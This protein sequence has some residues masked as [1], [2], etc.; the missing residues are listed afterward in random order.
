MST[1]PVTTKFTVEQ[2]LDT[3]EQLSPQELIEFEDQFFEI[4]QKRIASFADENTLNQQ[5]AYQFPEK[6][7]LRMRKLLS[8][9]NAGTITQAEKLEL[10]GLIEEFEQKS[11]EKAEAMSLL[12]QRKQ[13]HKAVAT[14]GKENHS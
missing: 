13:K 12:A 1:A 4:K 10:D 5:I 7:K 14:E 3:L 9:N 11:L 2:L 6:K 8:K